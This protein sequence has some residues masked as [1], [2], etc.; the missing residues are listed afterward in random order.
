MAEAASKLY[1]SPSYLSRLFAANMQESFSR[2]LMRHRIT[3]AKKMMRDPANKMY[4]I[5]LAVGYSDLAHFSKAF[6]I[7]EGVSPRK[8]RESGML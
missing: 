1:L 8:Y 6:K 2:Y 5:A 3:L 4:K 7:I